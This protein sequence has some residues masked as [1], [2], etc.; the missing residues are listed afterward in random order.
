[1]L[2][3]DLIR[4]INRSPKKVEIIQIINKIKLLR[5]AWK[6]DEEITQIIINCDFPLSLHL[7][8]MANYSDLMLLDT[9]SSLIQ[10]EC[11][12]SI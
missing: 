12:S 8:I 4:K 9:V 1:M 2:N 3:F 11:Q 6:T 5:K 7:F 10:Q